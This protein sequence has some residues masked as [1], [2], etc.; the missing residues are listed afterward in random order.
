VNRFRK[1]TVDRFQSPGQD[2]DADVRLG[3][4]VADAHKLAFG[5]DF[6]QVAV[7][8]FGEPWMP[9]L[10]IQG[11]PWRMLFTFLPSKI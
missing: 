4:P 9:L 1:R 10:K 5:V 3:V 7:L 6:T 2:A 11:W 8:Q